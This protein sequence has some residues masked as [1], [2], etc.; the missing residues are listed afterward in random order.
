MKIMESKKKKREREKEEEE[1]MMLSVEREK[2]RIHHLLELLN[3]AIIV[4]VVLN[5][6]LDR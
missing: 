1:K 3:S 5:I 6:L 4:T 2:Q